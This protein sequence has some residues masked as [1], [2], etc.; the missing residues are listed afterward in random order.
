[1]GGMALISSVLILLLP[2]T[3]NK[4]LPD[5]IEEAVNLRNANT[6]NKETT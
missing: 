2:E 6:K 3:I 1:M 5:T 4:K